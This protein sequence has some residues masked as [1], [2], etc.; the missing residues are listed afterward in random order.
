MIRKLALLLV[1]AFGYAAS[2]QACGDTGAKHSGKP[3]MS[4]PA[5]PKTG[6]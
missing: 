3:D 5:T 4:K 6:T 2:I 1:L